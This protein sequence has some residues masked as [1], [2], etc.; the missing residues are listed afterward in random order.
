VYAQGVDPEDS[1]GESNEYSS[2]SQ[3]DDEYSNMSIK[4]E[5]IE[6]SDVTEDFNHGDMSGDDDDGDSDV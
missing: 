3:Y 4:L 6:T 1:N 2:Y 5:S